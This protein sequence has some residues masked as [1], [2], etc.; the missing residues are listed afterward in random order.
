MDELSSLT[1]K[2]TFGTSLR[3]AYES[4]DDVPIVSANHSGTVIMVANG[5]I[6][7]DSPVFAAADGKISASGTRNLG[8]SLEPS[9]GDGDYIEVIRT[10][11]AG[12]VNVTGSGGTY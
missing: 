8:T 11:A 3:P 10:T 4:G 1:M 2:T 12:T 7:A 6:P 5:V 9:I